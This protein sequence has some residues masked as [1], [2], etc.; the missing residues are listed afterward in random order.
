MNRRVF[1]DD[2]FR[3]LAVMILLFKGYFVFSQP[4]FLQ[5]I[6]KDKQQEIELLAYQT[7]NSFST[8][9]EVKQKYLSVQNR[10]I[11]DGFI[12]LK[13]TDL[14]REND[15]LYIGKIDLGNH[16][17]TLIVH[18]AHLPKSVRETAQ[19]KGDSLIIPT[20]NFEQF[21]DKSLQLFEKKGFPM[22]QIAIQH[23]KISENTIEIS[24]YVE[25]DIERKIKQLY[26][27][28]YPNFPK[29]IKKFVE[30]K[31]KN[32]QL[33]SE[34]TTQLEQEIFRLPYLKKTRE[35]EVLFTEH[36]TIL[37]INAEKHNANHF[38]GLIGFANNEKSKKMIF[39]GYINL[40]LANTLNI[41][42]TIKLHW[43]NDGNNQS[44]LSLENIFP[45]IFSTPLGLSGEIQIFKQ[46]SLMQNTQLALDLIYSL[47]LKNY[48][49]I[50]IQSKKSTTTPS[51]DFT[52]ED[53]TNKFYTFSH[54]ASKINT[55]DL[56]PTV[57][58]TSLKIGFGTREKFQTVSENQWFVKWQG[59]KLWKLHPKHY[60]NQ[61][62]E[63]YYLDTE[64]PLFNE[65]YRFGGQGS[66]RGFA[67]N[68][69][70]TQHLIG[71]YQEIR[72]I[73]GPMMYSFA[74]LDAAFT[75][76]NKQWDTFFSAG[77]GIGLHT[78][79]GIF[80]LSYAVGKFPNQ[81]ISMQ[82]AIFHIGYKAKF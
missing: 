79:S 27:Q 29:N 51:N 46:D 8:Y 56:F 76:A 81:S 1:Y 33:S 66:I 47:N 42:E 24:L 64:N 41:G 43:K 38:D 65:L 62:I 14:H 52:T 11:N 36:A 55:E 78:H 5:L 73:L 50:G 17:H 68:S 2:F 63:Y 23:Q 80:D 10:L 61:Q 82:N 53:F 16:F 40:Q 77:L 35:S 72:Q 44:L 48:L 69:L 20:K 22:T 54:Q 67:Q 28:S 25:Q 15:S 6:G 57:W 7:A 21:I 4:Y 30:R 58:N 70:Y 9:Q 13:S 12:N 32:K 26:F 37:Y 71:S 49:G 45:N 39:N 60:I 59:T 18:I 31:Y 74:L 19:W 3:F 34:T 75:N